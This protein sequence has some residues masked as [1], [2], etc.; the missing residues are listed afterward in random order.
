MLLRHARVV[1]ATGSG[2]KKRLGL[3]SLQGEISYFFQGASFILDCI[4]KG[5]MKEKHPDLIR[6]GFREIVRKRKIRREVRITKKKQ[7]SF[8]RSRTGVVVR[9]ERVLNFFFGIF[10]KNG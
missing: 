1:R 7:K 10:N 9:I 5:A 8:F 4:A 2:I 6:F 3:F